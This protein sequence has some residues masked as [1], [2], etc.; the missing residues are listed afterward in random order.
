MVWYTAVVCRGHTVSPRFPPPDKMCWLGLLLLQLGAGL[1]E[2]QG[3][4][5]P[6]WRGLCYVDLSHLSAYRTCWA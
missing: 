2:R 5:S 4:P 3:R 1:M 6:R